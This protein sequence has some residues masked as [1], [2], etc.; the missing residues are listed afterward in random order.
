MD[1]RRGRENCANPIGNLKG[2]Y[3]AKRKKKGARGEERGIARRKE[4]K[5][6]SKRASFR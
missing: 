4:Q 1:G 2:S 5:T 3:T 6:F